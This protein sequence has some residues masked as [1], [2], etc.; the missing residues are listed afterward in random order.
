VSHN[1]SCTKLRPLNV[2][3][4]DSVHRGLVDGKLWP[5]NNVQL[6]EALLVAIRQHASSEFSEYAHVIV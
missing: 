6:W 5:R 1:T 3:R 4:Y 2:I